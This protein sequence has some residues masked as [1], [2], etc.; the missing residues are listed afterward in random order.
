MRTA[1]ATVARKMV[2]RLRLPEWG[3]SS[4]GTIDAMKSEKP[5]TTVLWSSRPALDNEAVLG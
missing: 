5:E 1:Y 2:H 3:A 4:Y